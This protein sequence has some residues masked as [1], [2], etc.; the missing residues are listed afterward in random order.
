[1]PDRAA[2]PPGMRPLPRA[3]YLPHGP[4]E[5]LQLYPDFFTDGVTRLSY[6]SFDCWT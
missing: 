5:Y 6:R 1:M 2:V 4:P 3:Y